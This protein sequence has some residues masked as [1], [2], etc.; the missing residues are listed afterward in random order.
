MTDTEYSTTS[1]LNEEDNIISVV[2]QTKATTQGRSQ[3]SP[4]GPGPPQ[5]KC[6]FKFLG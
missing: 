1:G 3:G 4:G 5:S 6:C 2:E